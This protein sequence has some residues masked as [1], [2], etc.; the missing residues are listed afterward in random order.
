M[1]GKRL[2]GRPS[3]FVL[4]DATNT[5]LAGIGFAEGGLTT[6][7]GATYTTANNNQTI[8]AKKFTDTTI[9]S[10][11][12]TGMTFEHCLWE[13]PGGSNDK[14]VNMTGSTASNITF[15]D[16]TMRVTGC[17]RANPSGSGIEFV[18]LT[19]RANG[20]TV[21]RCD[22][23]GGENCFQGFGNG[24]IIQ[25][26]FLHWPKSYDP[27]GHNDTIEVYGGTGWIIRRNT[28]LLEDMPSSSPTEGINI[29]P[30]TDDPNDV[31]NVDIYE[32]YIDGGVFGPILIDTTQTFGGFSHTITNVRIYK[33]RFGGHQLNRDYGNASG[34]PVQ[35]SNGGM[36]RVDTDTAG[37]EQYYLPHSGA[38]ANFWDYCTSNPFGFSDLS[39]DRSGQ[40][41]TGPV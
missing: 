3:G 25:D 7:A 21:T 29:A 33:N 26:S 11:A 12:V 40:M 17:N 4:R 9:F 39:P 27:G 2:I 37:A 24:N 23:S 10:G 20:I 19:D 15:N 41:Y 22:L 5:G 1:A 36:T 28:I 38:N 6:V 31:V 16:C 13:L 8:T 18:M 34:G 30:W 32:N 14:C 35:N